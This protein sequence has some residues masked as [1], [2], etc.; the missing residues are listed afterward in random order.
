[1]N[2]GL[3]L[4]GGGARAAYQ[5][6]VLK[7]VS[8]I[9]GNPTDGTPFKIVT[10]ISAGAI[11]SSYIA[12]E[13]QNF[14]AAA[15]NLFHVWNDLK[16]EQVVNV[17]TTSFIMMA[18]R[19]IKDLTFGGFLGGKKA[20][21]ILDTNP[22]REFLAK[23]INFASL[24]HNLRTGILTGCSVTATN[25]RT[26]TAISF[27]D[28]DPRI[29]PWVRSS[30]MGQRSKL[31]LEHVLA[32]ASVPILF[33]PV[34]LDGSYF[35]DGCIRLT[36]PLSPA[37]HLGSDRILAI[38]V[39]YPRPHDFTLDINQSAQ[40]KDVSIADIAGV[41]LNAAFL[42]SIDSDVERMLRINQTVSLLSEEQRRKNPNQ[43]RQIPLMLIRPSEDLG[44]MALAQFKVFPRTLRYM[45]RGLG[46]NGQKGADLI[47]YLAFD[48]TYTHRLLELGYKDALTQRKEIEA[49]FSPTVGQ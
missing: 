30:R 2:C 33:Q 19:W 28:G 23:R 44:A 29:E 40:M 41:M 6:G 25:Y 16:I 46:V 48:H 49:F 14:A 37:I 38:G 36:T 4:T 47:S 17:T 13:S 7:G 9:L 11:N 24:D 42:D 39:R 1:M 31:A 10:G 26:G 34:P 8:E 5:S 35:G 12:A 20:T 22:L 27:Y 43:L 32:S 21:H 45:L 3:V 18:A 15:E